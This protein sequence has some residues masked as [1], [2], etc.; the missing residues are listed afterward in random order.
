MPAPD[1]SDAIALLN[2]DHRKVEGLFE[3]ARGAGVVIEELG[4]RLAAR[5][6]DLL[7]QFKANG[8]PAPEPRSFPGHTIKQGE[9]VASAGLSSRRSILPPRNPATVRWVL[10]S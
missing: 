5:K 8:L 1:H 6:K 2:A 3:K 7:A 4:N 9:P 10:D